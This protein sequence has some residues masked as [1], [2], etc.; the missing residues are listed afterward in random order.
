MLTEGL[1]VKVQIL[2]MQLMIL[3]FLWSATIPLDP[4]TSTNLTFGNWTNVP[5]KRVPLFYLSS[6]IHSF[7]SLAFLFLGCVLIYST[8]TC[9][10]SISFCL[11]IVDL[12]NCLL[13]Y[14]PARISMT[15]LWLLWLTFM[16]ILALLNLAN[17]PLGFCTFC[18]WWEFRP[19]HPFCHKL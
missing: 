10:L 4:R 19:S 2:R 7:P 3:I 14:G 9:A 13:L 8:C 1:N 15:G 17:I 18:S 11:N 12:V 16:C 5:H 6:P